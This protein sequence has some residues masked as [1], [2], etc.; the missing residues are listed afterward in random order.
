MEK[1]NNLLKIASYIL[2]AFAAIAL[3]VSVVNIFRTL[4][5]VNNM[6]AATQ[7]A[8]DQAVA[9]NAGSGVS[10]D[11]AVG[12]VSGIAYVTLAITVAF[13]VL[14]II[15][16]I[17]GIKKSEVMGSNNFFMIWGIVFLIF[18]VF[19]LAGTLSLIGFC[20]LMA[21]IAAPLLYIIFARQTKAA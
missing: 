21:G 12:L 18:G 7:A 2:I 14:K 17:L 5:Q 15:I 19:G 4:G 11:M 8:L 3:V 20:N 16:G 1:K 10:A 9:A 6:D 13:N